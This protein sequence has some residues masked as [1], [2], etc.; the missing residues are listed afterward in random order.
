M[1]AACVLSL[2]SAACVSLMVSCALVPHCCV[3]RTGMRQWVC[4]SACARVVCCAA[5]QSVA[6]LSV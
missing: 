2:A 1:C 3:E 5:A 4:A 6:V